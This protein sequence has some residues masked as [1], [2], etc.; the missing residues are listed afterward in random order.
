MDKRQNTKSGYLRRIW[1]GR[2]ILA[3]VLAFMSCTEPL[4]AAGEPATPAEPGVL[5][6]MAIYNNLLIPDKLAPSA[7]EAG[8]G[9]QPPTGAAVSPGVTNIAIGS[10]LSYP[11]APQ[12]IA[13]LDF[14]REDEWASHV[15][16]NGVPQGSTWNDHYAG[17]G[18]STE[19]DGGYYRAQPVTFSMDKSV[20]N[21][22]SA[23]VASNQPYAA[24]IASPLIPLGKGH[25]VR[26]VVRYLLSNLSNALAKTPAGDWVSLGIK[27]DAAAD[28]NVVYANGYTRGQWAELSETVTATGDRVMVLLQAQSPAALNSN[29]YFDDVEIF[30]DGKPLS[31]C[32]YEESFL[33]N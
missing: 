29:V 5:D 10:R 11:N 9:I 17:W 14:N 13:C 20:G 18:A 19:D 32:R 22:I 24:R 25:E 3:F 15:V 12:P 28:D 4:F 26:V 1:A 6:P 21:V 16:L 27:L 7:R 8:N 2:F 33:G 31:D 30:I 23:K